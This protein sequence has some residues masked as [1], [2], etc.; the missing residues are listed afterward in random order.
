MHKLITEEGSTARPDWDKQVKEMVMQ[1]NV[2]VHPDMEYGTTICIP[3]NRHLLSIRVSPDYLEEPTITV[4][5]V[6]KEPV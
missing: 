6:T 5:L 4:T 3:F 2:T 1:H